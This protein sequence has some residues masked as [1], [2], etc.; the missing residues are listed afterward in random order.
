MEYW[1]SAG[2][3]QNLQELMG[4]GKVLDGGGD[5]LSATATAY[6]NHNI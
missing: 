6:S 2:F 4:E 3:W 5:W 1:H